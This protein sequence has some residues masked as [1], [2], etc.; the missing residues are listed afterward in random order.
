MVEYSIAAQT[1]TYI[2]HRAYRLIR[3]VD[4]RIM[5]LGQRYHVDRRG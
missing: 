2:Y 5:R 1:Q 3:S 4:K